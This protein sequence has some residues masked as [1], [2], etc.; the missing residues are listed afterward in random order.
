MANEPATLPDSSPERPLPRFASN[1]VV[2]GKYGYTSYRG[3]KRLLDIGLSLFFIILLS[4]IMLIIAAMIVVA[5]GFPVLFR[6]KRIGEGGRPI[7]MLKFRTMVRNAEE[8]LKNNPKLMEEFQRTFKLD[9]DPRVLKFGNFL[10]KTSL[11]ELP[12]L[13]NVLRG[14]MSIVGPRPILEKEYELHGDELT[15]YLQMKP[16]CAGLWQCSG[17]SET[18]Y[19]E[20]IA[21]D[22]HYFRSASIRNDLK[23]LVMTFLSILKREGAK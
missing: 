12:Q 18:T 3:V 19:E 5:D 2:R 22:E 20:R 4:P 1:L 14:D 15:A 21:L 11:D 7:Y 6:S 13:F 17:R 23:I 8:I 16:G 10:R 9:P